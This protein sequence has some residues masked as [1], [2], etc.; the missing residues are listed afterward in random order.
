MSRKGKTGTNLLG[1]V[2][3]PSFKEEVCLVLC[4]GSKRTLQGVVLVPPINTGSRLAKVTTAENKTHAAQGPHPPTNGLCHFTRKTSSSWGQWRHRTVRWKSRTVSD[5]LPRLSCRNKPE[6]SSSIC[7]W[8][9]LCVCP[10]IPTVVF[11]FPLYIQVA[12]CTSFPGVDVRKHHKVSGLENREKEHSLLEAR[13]L[14]S[15]CQLD[16]FHKDIRSL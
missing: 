10:R 1:D 5:S 4:G 15:G 16:S 11:V 14:G 9:S 2:I 12:H 13:D 6:A 7:W 8:F 3:Y